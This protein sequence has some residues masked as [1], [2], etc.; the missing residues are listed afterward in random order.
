MAVLL[1]EERSLEGS[2]FKPYIDIL[3]KNL[4]CFPINYI[5]EELTQLIGSPFLFQI[6][7]KVIDL[8]KDYDAICYW[9]D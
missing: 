8:K 7:E 6:R 5:T 1:L 2:R 3:P 9:S 4:Q